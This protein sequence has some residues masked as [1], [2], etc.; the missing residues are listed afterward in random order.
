M[1]RAVTLFA[2]S[3]VAWGCD[4][5]P[6]AKPRALDAERVAVAPATV[7]PPRHISNGGRIVQPQVV[8]RVDPVLPE[9]PRRH[10]KIEVE[11]VVAS[12]GSVKDAKLRNPQGGMYE[13]AII[14]AVRQW[15]YTPGI[16]D[17]EPAEMTTLV[18]V[19]IESRQNA[20]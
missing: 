8:H 10:V 2:L 20:P 18:T 5:E 19:N 17:N 7:A 9:I 11:V 16:V 15:R 4:P 1:H 3:V 14:E 12:D 6:P 13:R